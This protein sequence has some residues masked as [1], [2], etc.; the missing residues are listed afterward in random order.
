MQTKRRK[1]HFIEGVEELHRIFEERFAKDDPPK[2]KP[3]GS[4]RKATEKE[5]T[6]PQA[7]GIFLAGKGRGLIHELYSHAESGFWRLKNF[8]KRKAT[9][10]KV[11]DEMVATLIELGFLLMTKNAAV[12]TE[13]GENAFNE[14]SMRKDLYEVLKTTKSNCLRLGVTPKNGWID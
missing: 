7:R 5:Y 2:K 1:S 8:P 13:A 6:L 10:P 4:G 3:P 9:Q 11:T 12:L 14:I